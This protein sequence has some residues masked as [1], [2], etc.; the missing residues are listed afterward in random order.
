M[1]KHPLFK[2]LRRLV[3]HFYSL[4]NGKVIQVEYIW[5]DGMNGLRSKSRTLNTRPSDAQDLPSWNYDGSSTG[6]AKYVL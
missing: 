4:S 6:Q 3:Q 5:I 1:K 2:T